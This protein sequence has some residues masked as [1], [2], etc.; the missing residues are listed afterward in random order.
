[1]NNLKKKKIVIHNDFTNFLINTEK[2]DDPL[3]L[4]KAASRD[5]IIQELEIRVQPTH[6][7]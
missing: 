4:E 6:A 7:W 5:V 3:N 1:M 2:A